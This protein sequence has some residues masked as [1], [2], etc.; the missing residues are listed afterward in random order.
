MTD[1]DV[2]LL[3]RAFIVCDERCVE[4]FGGQRNKFE[5]TEKQHFVKHKTAVNNLAPCRVKMVRR[6]RAQVRRLRHIQ[7]K[8][9]KIE[10][11]LATTTQRTKSIINGS[12][13]HD[14][15]HRTTST[16]EANSSRGVNKSGIKRNEELANV[17][18][19]AVISDDRKQNSKNLVTQSS[20]LQDK[21][22][23]LDG[24]PTEQIKIQAKS[25]KSIKYGN[26]LSKQVRQNSL[27]KNSKMEALTSMREYPRNKQE[28]RSHT[29]T[30]AS[31]TC[32]LSYNDPCVIRYE[33]RM[34][35]SFNN[36]LNV[37]NITDDELFEF[38]KAIIA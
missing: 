33:A 2:S 12:L 17:H 22:R 38:F 21:I 29:F 24:L 4:C 3:N 11:Q 27:G 15:M 6:Q 36:P 20:M 8:I 23:P 13:E 37:L 5:A 1:F 18:H 26:P 32:T 30:E 16:K 35:R 31:R 19:K 14:Q 34:M 7:K 28:V 9:K 25:D 10:A